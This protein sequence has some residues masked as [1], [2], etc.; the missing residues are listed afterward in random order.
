LRIKWDVHFEVYLLQGVC[1]LSW[2]LREVLQRRVTNVRLIAGIHFCLNLVND[3]NGDPGGDQTSYWLLLKPVRSL[4]GRIVL[5][6]NEPSRWRNVQ[7]CYAANCYLPTAN[8]LFLLLLLTN[9]LTWHIVQKLQGHVTNKKKNLTAMCSVDG[10]TVE[11][12]A[13]SMTSQ[14]STSLSVA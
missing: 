8:L 9:R 13:I 6:G 14:T 5:R 11:V 1:L 4:R 12:G 10:S 7:L 3:W 2:D